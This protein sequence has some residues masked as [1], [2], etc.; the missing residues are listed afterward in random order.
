MKEISVETWMWTL[1]GLY[2][3]FGVFWLLQRWLAR[4]IQGLALL[5]FRRPGPAASLYFFLI[6]PGVAIHE[7][8]HW[9]FAKLLFVRTGNM[10][11]FRPGS[12]PSGQK[13]KIT[14]GYVEIYRSDPIR[15]SLIGLA[16]LPVGI[17]VLLILA[18][19]LGINQ[20]ISNQ[21]ASGDLL[22]TFAALPGQFIASLSKPL[23]ILWLYLVFTVSNGMLPSA[24]DRKPWLVGFFVPAIIIIGLT[25]AGGL[26]FSVQTQQGFLNFI[27]VLTWV[28]AFAAVF[29]FLLAFC[30]AGLE[31]LVS[32]FSQRRIV[33]RRR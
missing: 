24:P 13:G 27:G 7:L 12:K 31:F 17:L 19:L 29:N 28:F 30:I 22:E 11:L 15:Q 18:V 25:L 3:T 23:N 21:A 5:L 1:I 26:K 16:P 32:H 14:L 9:S 20:Q 10:A 4:H 2:A 6:A 8:S 33:Y